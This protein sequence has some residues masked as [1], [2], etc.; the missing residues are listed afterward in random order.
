[1]TTGLFPLSMAFLVVQVDCSQFL[2][3]QNK[4]TNKMANTISYISDKVRTRNNNLDRKHI[5][6]CYVWLIWQTKPVLYFLLSSSK[7]Q[8]TCDHS[9]KLRSAFSKYTS[10]SS[11]SIDDYRNSHQ[12]CRRQVMCIGCDQE[13]EN[14]PLPSTLCKLVKLSR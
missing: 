6:K 13:R 3:P 7:S 5:W 4:K 9:S 14:Y 10:S 12:T 11:S 8:K 1:M 2:C